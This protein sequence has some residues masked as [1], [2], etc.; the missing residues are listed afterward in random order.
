MLMKE[1]DALQ[2]ELNKQTSKTIESQ[3]TLEHWKLW[4]E[5]LMHQSASTSQGSSSTSSTADSTP[6]EGLA[7]S[8]ANTTEDQE[9]Q[10]STKHD[11]RASTS[12]LHDPSEVEGFAD[13]QSEIAG[14]F[15]SK[16]MGS[17]TNSDTLIE[18]AL[19][20]RSPKCIKRSR[21]WDEK[22][23]KLEEVVSTSDSNHVDL[24]PVVHR[25]AISTPAE[26]E[27]T[28]LWMSEMKI[29][30]NT[31]EWSSVPNLQLNESCDT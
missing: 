16:F 17:Y 7:M 26:T 5:K 20:P 6:V 29:D 30:F 8:S 31:W 4:Y 22:E 9:P 23:F 13:A 2:E 27:D 11:D 21:T 3:A 12:S 28:L 19:C 15:N 25:I 18:R 10:T 14:I 1:L 24:P